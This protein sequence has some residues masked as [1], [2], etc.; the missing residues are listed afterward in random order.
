MWN[1]IL[2]QILLEIKI[3]YNK[4]FNKIKDARLKE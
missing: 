3:F 4:I 1:N 2:K